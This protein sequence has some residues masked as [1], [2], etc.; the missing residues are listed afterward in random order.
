[1]SRRPLLTPLALALGL[2]LG[3]SGAAHADDLLQVYQAARAYDATYLAA[4]AQAESAPYRAEQ[5]RALNRPNVG[6][7]STATANSSNPPA[8]AFSATNPS[9]ATVGSNTVS[10]TLRGAQPLFNRTNSTTIAQA[11]KQL[12][13]SRADLETAEQDL[14]VRAAQAYFDVLA[15]QDTLSTTRQSKAAITEQLASAK[16]N[17]EVGTATITDTREAQARFDLATAQEIQAENDLLTKRIALDQLVGKP[18][19]TPNPLVTPVTLPQTTP[20]NVDEWVGSAEAQHPSVRRARLGLDIAR[21]E[22][23]KARAGHLPTVDAVATVAPT[24]NRIGSGPA[25]VQA[26]QPPG[27]TVNAG[28]GVQINVPLFSGFSVQ[29]RIRETL[30]LEEKSTNDLAAARRGVAQATRQVYFGVQSLQAQVKALEAAES[31]SRLALDA[32]QLGYKVGVRVNLDVLNAQTLVYQ[33]QRD[34]AR[35][36]YDVL[37]NSLRLRQAAGTLNPDDLARLNQLIAK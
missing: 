6:L 9:G 10:A 4:R 7:S 17:F 5:A 28:I 31:S 3:C 14:I 12:E 19:T 1:M 8:N 24:Y 37:L 26:A 18:N 33:T 13:I 34:L 23:E 21:L 32:T 30:V 2:A 25:L 20:A 29:N 16:R 22:T 27:T 11:E 35:A 36:R 15:A